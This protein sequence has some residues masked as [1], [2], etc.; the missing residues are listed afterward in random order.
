MA[1]TF[2][3]NN[4]QPDYGVHDQSMMVDDVEAAPDALQPTLGGN[5][6]PT[7]SRHTDDE[8][9]T[10]PNQKIPLEDIEAMMSIH[11]QMADE[12]TAMT[13]SQGKAPFCSFESG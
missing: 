12:Q 13:H 8:Y 3:P 10:P 4:S 9:A 2:N 6:S 1:P 11:E 5:S 7:G